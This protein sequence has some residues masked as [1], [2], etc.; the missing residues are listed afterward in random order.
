MHLR[1]VIAGI[2]EKLDYFEKNNIQSI[3][4]QSSIFNVSDELY[5]LWDRQYAKNKIT[6]L[7]N[8]DPQI[9]NEKDFH[10]FT[11]ALTKKS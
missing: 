2:L 1:F 6:D 7:F 9:G 8:L 4:L 10:D 5:E 3:L 11:E